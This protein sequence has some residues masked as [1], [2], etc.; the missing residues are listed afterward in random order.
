MEGLKALF[1]CEIFLNFAIVT[2]SFIFD[3]YCLIMY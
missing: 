1:S 2:P 3:K